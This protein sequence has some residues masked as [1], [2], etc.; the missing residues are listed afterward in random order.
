MAGYIISIVGGKGGVGKSMFA[1]NF[2]FGLAQEARTKTLLLD[3]ITNVIVEI[4]SSIDDKLYI[5]STSRNILKNHKTFLNHIVEWIDV[6]DNILQIGVLRND[7]N[8]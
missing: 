7:K 8:D 3:L 2:V 5:S 4:R 1:G 6:R